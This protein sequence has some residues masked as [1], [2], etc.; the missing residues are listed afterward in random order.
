VAGVLARTGTAD[1][2]LFFLPL[3]AAQA[4]FGQA[5][6]LSAVAI[7]LNDPADARAAAAGF[8]RLP[9][10]QVVTMT[11]MVGTFLNLVG[12]VRTMAAALVLV[13]LAIGTLSVFNTLFGSVLEQ[14]RDLAVMRAV[15]ASRPHL[16]ANILLQAAA[17]AAA[18]TMLGLLLAFAGGRAV[19]AV[20]R[21]WVPLAPDGRL[22]QLSPG[23]ALRAAAL[24][25][26][27]ASAAGIYPAWRASRLPP[28]LALRWE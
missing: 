5:G 26:L 25:A 18:G 13:A 10:V 8:Q 2:S 9:G 20:I 11:E 3:P 24:A 19:E 16:L 12:S 7:R 23:V 28:G 4:A 14:T 22:L 17:L 15:G 21:G 1:D 27:A 6:R